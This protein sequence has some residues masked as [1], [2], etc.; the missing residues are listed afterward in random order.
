[1]KKSGGI[2]PD[3]NGAYAIDIYFELRDEWTGARLQT[4]LVLTCLHRIFEGDHLLASLN[5]LYLRSG[6]RTP[7]AV[8]D[9]LR[10]LHSVPRFREV[11]IDMPNAFKEP[12]E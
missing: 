11:V 9:F 3:T 2:E 1:M 4:A 6:R 7:F 10:Q 5:P 12:G 8:G